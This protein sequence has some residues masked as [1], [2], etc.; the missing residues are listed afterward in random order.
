MEEKTQILAIP[1]L[2]FLEVG[3]RVL[4]SPQKSSLSPQTLKETEKSRK[5]N[6]E[7]PPLLV[8]LNTIP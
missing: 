5:K 2:L 3:F 7:S 6:L 8:I 4:A 1:S